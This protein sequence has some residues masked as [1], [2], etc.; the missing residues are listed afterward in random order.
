M[1]TPP[2][3]KITSTELIA[4]LR[5]YVAAYA[6][7]QPDLDGM[8]SYGSLLIGIYREV[9]ARRVVEYAVT[10]R[11][12]TNTTHH[13]DR[14]VLAGLQ[15]E[16][17]MN[18]LRSGLRVELRPTSAEYH[19]IVADLSRYEYV[20]VVCRGDLVRQVMAIDVETLH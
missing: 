4:H 16:N 13:L 8:S 3:G 9:R 14:S 1:A 15:F 18:I 11:G 20:T 12:E 5:A 6:A 17:V 19:R 10:L 2:V 7:Y